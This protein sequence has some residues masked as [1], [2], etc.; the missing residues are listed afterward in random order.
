MLSTGQGRPQFLFIAPSSKLAVAPSLGKTRGHQTLTGSH[1]TLNAQRPVLRRRPRVTSRLKTIVAANGYHALAPDTAPPDA[2]LVHT[3]RWAPDGPVLTRLVSREFVKLA[4]SPDA[5][6][7]TVRCSPDGPV[8]TGLVRR[9][10]VKLA[11]SPDGPVLTGLVRR[12]GCKNPSHRT[13]TTGRSQSAS[14]A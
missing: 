2:Q 6:H 3:G 1:R 13:L 10:G 5:R 11:T 4:T 8:L 12:E 7:R 14:G 9:E